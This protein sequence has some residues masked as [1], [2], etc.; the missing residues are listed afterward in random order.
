M[1]NSDAEPSLS[2]K[3]KGPQC[4]ED[5]VLSIHQKLIEW[6]SRSGGKWL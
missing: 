3:T 2:K 6:L 5:G 1:E 4:R